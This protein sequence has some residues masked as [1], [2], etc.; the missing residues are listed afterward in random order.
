MDRDTVLKHSRAVRLQQIVFPD[1]VELL[2]ELCRIFDCN[3]QDIVEF[4]K[5]K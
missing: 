1:F 3:T 4:K 5:H 2:E